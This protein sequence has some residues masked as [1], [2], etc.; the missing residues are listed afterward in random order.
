MTDIIEKLEAATEGSRELDE[1]IC[2]KLK[3]KWSPDEGGNY[4]A[5]NM[6]PKRVWFTRITD[7]AMSLIPKDY[8]WQM[9]NTPEDYY[10]GLEKTRDGIRATH[11]YPITS[12]AETLELAICIAALKGW[13]QGND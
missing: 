4:G 9:E 2:K 8:W 13:E 11:C 7:A 12:N 6:L 3:I 1:A 10:V 5:Y